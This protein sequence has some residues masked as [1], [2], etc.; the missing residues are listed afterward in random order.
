MVELEVI[1]VSDERE[2]VIVDA[3]PL[4]HTID[5]ADTFVGARMPLLREIL[6]RTDREIQDVYFA[7]CLLDPV[8]ETGAAENLVVRMRSDDEK[9]R[10]FGKFHMLATNVEL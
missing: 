10:F 4:R 8:H 7:A 1:F 3:H 2:M 9:D 6:R 5:L